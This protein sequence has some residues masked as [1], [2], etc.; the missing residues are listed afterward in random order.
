MRTFPEYT[1][2]ISPVVSALAVIV[3]Y[4]TPEASDNFSQSAVVVAVQTA[5]GS[6]GE[7]TI[8]CNIGFDPAVALRVRTGGY[9]ESGAPNVSTEAHQNNRRNRNMT[10]GPDAIVESAVPGC[11]FNRTLIECSQP[12]ARLK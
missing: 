12:H 5:P 2:G 9:S 6:A 3:R 1:P 11:Q 4:P 7:T 8:G 10:S